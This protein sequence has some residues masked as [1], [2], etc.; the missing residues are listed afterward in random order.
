MSNL[1]FYLARVEE[2][3]ANADAALLDNVRDRHLRAL[4][5]W[6]LLAQQSDRTERFRSAD[7]QR[8]EQQSL[9]D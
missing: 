8:K 1:A 3:R 5:A 9:G 2:A 6:S 7:A 4:A